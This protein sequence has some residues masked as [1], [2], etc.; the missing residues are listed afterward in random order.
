MTVHRMRLYAYFIF[1]NQSNTTWQKNKN[2]AG[3]Q[4]AGPGTW[5]PGPGTR[6]LGPVAFRGTG[7]GTAYAVVLQEFVVSL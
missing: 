5:D 4:D 7:Y 6:D 3:T 2:G 1:V